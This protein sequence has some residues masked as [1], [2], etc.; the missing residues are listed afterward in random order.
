MSP[1]AAH[2]K[3]SRRC[4]ATRARSAALQDVVTV[5]TGQDT[6]TVKY[7]KPSGVQR[8][9]HLCWKKPVI[10]R[11]LL[12][13]HFLLVVK[14]KLR[15]KTSLCGPE[16]VSRTD[17]RLKIAGSFVSQ[18]KVGGGEKTTQRVKETPDS[19]KQRFLKAQDP[20]STKYSR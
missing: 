1:S 4:S 12:E 18:D 2:G 3:H 5:F 17:D 20:P 9:L 19:N 8:K 10:K 11:L 13:N 6:A 14:Y 16:C 7:A 15:A